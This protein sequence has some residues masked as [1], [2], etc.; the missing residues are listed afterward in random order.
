LA[1]A[2]QL[3]LNKLARVTAGLP[4]R[5][6]Q[7]AN[8]HVVKS[9]DRIALIDDGRTWTY[10][11]LDRAVAEL[12][13]ALGALSIRPGDRVI[14]VSDNCVALAALVLAVSRMDAWAIV[15]NPGLSGREL[16]Q[17]RVH[18][19]A[20]RMLFTT[21]VSTEAMAHASRYDA[22]KG[23]LGPFNEIGVGAL[24]ESA[25]TEPVEIDAA[26]QV[27]VLIYT[28]SAT[29]GPRGAMLTHDNLLFSARIT[30]NFRRIDANEK[31][32]I[33]HPIS[34]IAG[35]SLLIMTLMIGGTV[36][37]VGKH[38]PAVLAKAI[39]EDNIKGLNGMPAPH[40]QP[41]EHE[42]V[43]GAGRS[44][45][46]PP[47]RVAVARAHLDFDLKAR[48]EREFDLPLS[49]GNLLAECSSA[50]SGVLFK[51]PLSEDGTGALLQGVEARVRTIDGIPL[52]RGEV[53]ELHVRGRNVVRGYYRAPDLT[54]EF[55]DSEGWFNTGELA[56]FHGDCVQLVGHSREVIVRSG[57]NV[58]P[59]EVE[60]FLNSHKDVV[61]SAVVGRVVR[62][63]EEI[64]AFVQMAR[65]SAVG[66]DDLMDYARGRLAFHKRPSEI[67][68]LDAL[69]ATSSGKVLKP[70][71]KES[72]LDVSHEGN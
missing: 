9:L 39:A 56:R 22:L 66:P 60:A 62:G 55:I 47:G 1:V 28:S 70:I 6:H 31:R 33:T 58:D 18:C 45:G 10:R 24:E 7:I 46:G 17:I 16:D 34:H 2:T 53:G 64:V 50:I 59:A 63:N 30:A 15:A 41:F 19:S 37:L 42:K 20:R 4:R 35:M 36:R 14:I 65:R 25:T 26:H 68:L 67:I 12:V 48:V 72:L 40:Q 44:A 38:D 13:D 49:C 43:V 5:I 52:G 61:R 54:A 23:P 29:G 69:P 57:L 51:G 21:D 3:D 71:L 11:E 8:K 32:Y 27:A